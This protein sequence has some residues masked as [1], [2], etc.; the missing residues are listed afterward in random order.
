MVI[1][2]LVDAALVVINLFTGILFS[3]EQ[4]TNIYSFGKYYDL[5]YLPLLVYLVVALRFIY[6][7]EVRVFLMVVV[8]ILVRIL[9]RMQ[10]GDISSTSFTLALILCYCHIYAMNDPFYEKEFPVKEDEL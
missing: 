8:L 10:V 7:I 6:K 2:F 4:G 3:V 1:P 9:F 5:I